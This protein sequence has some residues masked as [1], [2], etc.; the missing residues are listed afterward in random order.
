MAAG[1]CRLTSLIVLGA[2]T[3]LVCIGGLLGNVILLVV[4]A[5]SPRKT[6]TTTLLS[7][8]AVMDIGI[9]VT[10][11]IN[12]SVHNL[13]VLD[14]IRLGAT[15]PFCTGYIDVRMALIFYLVPINTL[16]MTGSR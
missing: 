2:V 16:T 10:I 6:A 15:T 5:T 13:C 14:W 4:M 7:V 11:F 1:I 9:L 3:G 12:F 8:A